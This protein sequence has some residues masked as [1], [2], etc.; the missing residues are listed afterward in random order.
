MPIVVGNLCKTPLAELYYQSEIL[1]SL[2]DRQR[3]STECQG[4]YFAQ[5]CRGG[6]HCLAYA[7]TGDPFRAD[8]GCW[9]HSV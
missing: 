5:H 7:T 1:S 9:V 8:P 3:I 2:R 4:C 6:L